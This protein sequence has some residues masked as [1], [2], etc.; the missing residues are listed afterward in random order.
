MEDR[1]FLLTFGTMVS[2]FVGS[3]MVDA[4]DSSKFTA[5]MGSS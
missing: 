1:S 4:L 2:F 3:V 5:V